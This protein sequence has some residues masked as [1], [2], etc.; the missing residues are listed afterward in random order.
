M[1]VLHSAWS[2]GSLKAVHDRADA[3]VFPKAMMISV[4]TYTNISCRMQIILLTDL[5]PCTIGQHLPSGQTAEKLQ[6]NLLIALRYHAV[7]ANEEDQRSYARQ[8]QHVAYAMMR[9]QAD[10]PVLCNLEACA[11]FLSNTINRSFSQELLMELQNV[12][13]H[14]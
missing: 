3:L 8:S 4:T 5:R 6:A 9:Q 12:A 7:A 10:Q 14:G 1:P 11:R 2:A 13:I